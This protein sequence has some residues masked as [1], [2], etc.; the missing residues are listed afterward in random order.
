M[1]EKLIV[2]PHTVIIYMEFFRM[3]FVRL[4][5]QNLYPYYPIKNLNVKIDEV[6]HG[7][8]IST[9]D[10]AHGGSGELQKNKYCNYH[11]ITNVNYCFYQ[12]NDS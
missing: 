1:V 2:L 10:Q 6:I 5:L 7:N 9:Y 12:K 11:I 3:K 4:N 8:D